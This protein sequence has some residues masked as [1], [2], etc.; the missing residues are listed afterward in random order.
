MTHTFAELEISDTAYNEIRSKLESAGYEHAFMDDGAI[1]MHGIGVKKKAKPP[2][3][4]KTH[5]CPRRVESAIHR[6]AAEGEHLDYYHERDGVQCCSFC[7]SMNPDQFMKA[8]KDGHTVGPTDK[9]Y[10]VYIS[11]YPH[12]DPDGL[13]PVTIYSSK[14]P[15]TEGLI[16]VTEKNNHEHPEYRLGSWI[17]M[18]ENGPHVRAKFYFQHLSPRQK[19][20][21][22]QLFNEK[23][24]KIGVPGHF[25]VLP[26]F[27]QVA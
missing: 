17:K 2:E 14:P 19:A 26:Y 9:S 12:P 20:E 21:F 18:G 8:V 22:V 25:Y 7:G 1:D 13:R 23:K 16:E 6:Q 24:I 15:N 4:E 10:K 5:S 3:P 27:F 11:D